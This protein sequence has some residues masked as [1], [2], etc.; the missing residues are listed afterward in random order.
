[1][2]CGKGDILLWNVKFVVLR[3]PH[4]SEGLKDL[5]DAKYFVEK[6]L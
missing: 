3:P 4:V 5:D 2:K 6:I 1:M